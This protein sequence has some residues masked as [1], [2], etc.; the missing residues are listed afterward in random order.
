MIGVRMEIIS[1]LVNL[2]RFYKFTIK[3]DKF[4]SVLLF[5]YLRDEGPLTMDIVQ[6]QNFEFWKYINCFRL[7]A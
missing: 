5:F 6:D 4:N 7:L 3:C 1:C 2:W